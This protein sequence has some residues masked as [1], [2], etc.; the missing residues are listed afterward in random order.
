MNQMFAPLR[1]YADFHGRATRTEFWLFFL[2]RVLLLAAFVGGFVAVFYAT[3]DYPEE[4]GINWMTKCILLAAFASW[5]VLILPQLAVTVRRLHDQ[6]QSG[7]LVLLK[8][9]PLGDLV[10][11]VF[12]LLKGTAGTNRHG[13][14]PRARAD[15]P[16]PLFA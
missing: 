4:G 10:L 12:M 16:A 9:A 15:T 2:F 8:W 1:K 5:I 11:F 7:W 6:D 14:D 13:S 3:G